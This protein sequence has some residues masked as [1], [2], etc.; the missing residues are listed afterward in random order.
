M[1][2]LATVSL[3]MT[4]QSELA[5]EEDQ[6]IMFARSWARRMRRRSR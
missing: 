6:G 5:P 1:L 4:S 2:L 3:V